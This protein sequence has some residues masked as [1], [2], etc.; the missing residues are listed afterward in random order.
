MKILLILYKH[1]IMYIM[2][3]YI[4]LVS[5]KGR[6]HWKNPTSGF[7]HKSS[8]CSPYSRGI[9]LFLC[10]SFFR[11]GICFKSVYVCLKAGKSKRKC[12]YLLFLVSKKCLHILAWFRKRFHDQIPLGYIIRAALRSKYVAPRNS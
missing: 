6:I 10:F 9:L 5:E 8:C 2:C 12:V 7:W 1:A 11:G 4:F 3:I